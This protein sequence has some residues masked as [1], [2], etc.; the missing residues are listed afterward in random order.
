MQGVPSVFGAEPRQSEW[1]DVSSLQSAHLR[2][3][4]N[5]KGDAP[6]PGRC[7]KDVFGVVIAVLLAG[8]V[9]AVA[10]GI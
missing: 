2:A 8:L 4:A 5:A 6:S 3:C 1:S 9:S 7:E 10:L